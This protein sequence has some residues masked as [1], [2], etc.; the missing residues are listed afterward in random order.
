ME[1][2]VTEH[3][4]D[5]LYVGC[6][7]NDCRRWCHYLENEIP[8]DRCNSH[9]RRYREEPIS[10]ELEVAAQDYDSHRCALYAE[11]KDGDLNPIMNVRSVA[12]IYGAIWQ[13]EHMMKDAIDGVILK[14]KLFPGNVVGSLPE[15]NDYKR[16]E[17]VKLIIIKED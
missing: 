8:Y 2:K 11:D 1:D 13:K 16:N 4:C 17:K 3:K 15:D 10:E 9:C 6:H 12:F 14:N 7:I 5:C